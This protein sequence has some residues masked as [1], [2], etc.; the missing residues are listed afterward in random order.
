LSYNFNQL[1]FCCG[2]IKSKFFDKR[3]NM[4]FLIFITY[5]WELSSTSDM[6]RTDYKL[7]LLLITFV[8]TCL[9]LSVKSSHVLNYMQGL[10]DFQTNI[11]PQYTPHCKQ[12][13]HHECSGFLGNL[14]TNTYLYFF[15]LCTYLKAAYNMH[16]YKGT[17]RLCD[18]TT[19][20]PMM[21]KKLQPA[22]INLFSNLTTFRK[23]W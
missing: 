5:R 18:L 13:L 8:K 17:C 9:V 6:C 14:Q 4:I 3:G 19:T 7:H 12:Y 2:L 11:K 15:A 20:L 10:N 22:F 23:A 16:Q 21:L 1:T